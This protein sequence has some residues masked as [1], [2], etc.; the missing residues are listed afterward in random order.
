VNEWGDDWDR[1]ITIVPTGIEFALMDASMWFTE[2]AA[3]GIELRTPVTGQKLL[4]E[5]AE[6]AEAPSLEEAA[7]VMICLLGHVLGLGYT[8]EQLAGA[9][10]AKSTVNRVR[11]WPGR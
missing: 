5:A 9:I 2:L 10:L 3:Q 11:T 6:F 1:H 7:D 8:I 4:K